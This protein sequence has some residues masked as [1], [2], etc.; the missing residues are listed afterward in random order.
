MF[1]VMKRME[2]SGGHS[3]ALPYQSKCSTPHGHNWIVGVEVESEELNQWGMVVDF[4]HIKKIVNLLD[5]QNISEVLLETNSTAE[6]IAVW[7]VNKITIM[8]HEKYLKEEVHRTAV[9]TKVTIQE[10][11]GNVICYTP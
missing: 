3:L 7:L 5:H 8:L 9:V 4:T 2:V 1:T 11:E 10:S 6:N